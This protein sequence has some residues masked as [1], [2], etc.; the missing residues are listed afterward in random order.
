MRPRAP[1]RLCASAHFSTQKH[2]TVTREN[3]SK[4]NSAPPDPHRA[5]LADQERRF[6][7]SISQL[8]GV[9]GI[10]CATTRNLMHLPVLNP[11]D[12]LSLYIEFCPLYVLKSDCPFEQYANLLNKETFCKQDIIDSCIGAKWIATEAVLRL[13]KKFLASLDVEL[14]VS[15]VFWDTGVVLTSRKMVVPNLLDKH[16]ETYRNALHELCT[17]NQI[18]YDFECS[19]SYDQSDLPPQ[20]RVDQYSFIEEGEKLDNLPSETDILRLLGVSDRIDLSTKAGRRASKLFLKRLHMSYMNLGITRAL[21]HTYISVTPHFSTRA[22]MRLGME[23]VNIFLALASVE[24]SSP[25]AKLPAINI[26][27][28]C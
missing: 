9:D 12:T 16:A 10:K 4:M 28:S 13:T 15:A 17:S 26:L 24:S 20:W 3:N 7:A 27:Q 11:G 6:I 5:R 18:A 21:V 25:Q 2:T 8:V 19:S 23:V 22:H 14:H 1:F